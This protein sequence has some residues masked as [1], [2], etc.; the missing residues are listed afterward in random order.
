MQVGAVPRPPGAPGGTEGSE[1]RR[2]SVPRHRRTPLQTG[3]PE[4]GGPRVQGPVAP[5]R[6]APGG[7]AGA[8]AS[9][10]GPWGRGRSARPPSPAPRASPRALFASPHPTPLA[11]TSPHVHTRAGTAHSLTH[12][13]SGCDLRAGMRSRARSSHWAST[14]TSR[15]GKLPFGLRYLGMTKRYCEITTQQCFVGQAFPH[16]RN[17]PALNQHVSKWHLWMNC[18]RLE[19]DLLTSNCRG[20]SSLEIPIIFHMDGTLTRKT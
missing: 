10:R 15:A 8:R 16:L 19:T 13:P 2:P 11:H 20:S 1:G 3:R 9:R 4:G 12:T 6:R 14:K 7:A 18:R 17:C 5:P